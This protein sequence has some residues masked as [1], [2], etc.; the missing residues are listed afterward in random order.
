[1]ELWL[2]LYSNKST[3]PKKTETFQVNMEFILTLKNKNNK[4]IVNMWDRVGP[5]KWKTYSILW[6]VVLFS[7]QGDFFI[8][9]CPAP[10]FG[11]KTHRPHSNSFY[12]TDVRLRRM[13]TTAS[14]ILNRFYTSTLLTD[15]KILDHK[16]EMRNHNENRALKFLSE[17][18]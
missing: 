16:T 6:E 7:L 14:L 15:T 11:F 18:A 8:C 3:L 13:E 9:V 4:H 10:T 17:S 5:R 12:K 1:M 2:C